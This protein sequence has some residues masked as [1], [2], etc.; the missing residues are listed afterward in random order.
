MKRA[1]GEE[2][3]IWWCD[4]W[5]KIVPIICIN[6]VF[7]FYWNHENPSKI[8][9]RYPYVCEDNIKTF[10]ISILLCSYHNFFRSSTHKLEL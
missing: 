9:V 2:D 10:L 7:G 5:N 1:K 3:D 4:A 6:Y 8:Q